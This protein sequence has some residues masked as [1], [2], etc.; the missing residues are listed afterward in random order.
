VAKSSRRGG[1]DKPKA[2][3]KPTAEDPSRRG[4]A[5]RARQRAAGIVPSPNFVLIASDPLKAQIVAV[6]LHR[7]YSPSEYARESGVSIGV[8]SYAF[9]VL[10]ERGILELVEEVKVRGST[11]RHMYRATEAAIVGDADWGQLAEAL[12]PLFTGT[13]LQDFSTQTTRAI[14]TGHL[15]SRDDFCLYWAPRDYDEIAWKEQV[16]IDAWMIEESERLEADTVNRRA[17]GESEGSIHTTF[18]IAV[19]PT[20]T[21]TE[22]KQYEAAGKGKRESKKQAKSKSAKGSTAKGKSASKPKREGRT[23][24]TTKGKGKRRKS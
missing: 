24:K 12:R 5:K 23:G 11:I 2:K 8:A 18:A 9:K 7:L 1:R 21:H 3:G 19:F 22:Y 20:P 15:F 16:E 14:E 4:T 17:N 6:A 10:R 13:I